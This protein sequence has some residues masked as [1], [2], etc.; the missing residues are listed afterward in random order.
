M[1]TILRGS[2][3]KT[4]P[5]LHL[6]QRNASWAFCIIHPI[7]NEKLRVSI[8]EVKHC[9]TAFLENEKKLGSLLKS[10]HYKIGKLDSVLSENMTNNKN[11]VIDEALRSL[12]YTAIQI[13]KML[14][15]TYEISKEKEIFTHFP[16]RSASLFLEF[17]NKEVFLKSPVG[18]IYLGTHHKLNSQ[19]LK[20][21]TDQLFSYDPQFTDQAYYWE[22]KEKQGDSQTGFTTGNNPTPV[23]MSGNTYK[24]Q[25]RIGCGYKLL[26]MPGDLLDLTDPKVQKRLE[27]IPE[28]FKIETIEVHDLFFK[29]I[30]HFKTAKENLKL[31]L[32]T[33][34][35]YKETY[36]LFSDEMKLNGPKVCFGNTQAIRLFADSFKISPE[37]TDYSIHLINNESKN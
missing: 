25:K 27:D 8:E 6:Q 12:Y 22:L 15:L 28:F 18:S 13:H 19:N 4:R 16:Q 36:N 26:R 30:Y 10:T 33:I 31:A 3:C 14:Q 32:G 21:I 35:Y 17:Y 23:I 34:N 1:Q 7:Q 9:H 20:T 11:A 2:A 29:N 37:I 24:Y 5:A